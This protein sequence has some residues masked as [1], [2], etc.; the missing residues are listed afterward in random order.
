MGVVLKK[1]EFVCV[2]G[3]ERGRE[4]EKEG[5]VRETRILKGLPWTGRT[6]L[7]AR[8][9]STSLLK[10][11]STSMLKRDNQ[12]AP[13]SNLQHMELTIHVSK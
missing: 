4:G 11:L 8:I 12:E 3:R 13:I 7:A 5:G 10:E 2:R 6:Y 1:R 9:L